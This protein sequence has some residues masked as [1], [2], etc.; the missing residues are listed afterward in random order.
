MARFSASEYNLALPCV[1]LPAHTVVFSPAKL[2]R[3]SQILLLA[4]RPDLQCPNTRVLALKV[5]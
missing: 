5:P 4:T 1:F 3:A 2:A